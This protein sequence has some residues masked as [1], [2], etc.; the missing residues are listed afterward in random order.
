MN[1]KSKQLIIETTNI[2]P[3]HCEI[4]PRTE[5]KNKREIMSM[6]LFKK[7]IDESIQLGVE[8]YDFCGFGEPLTD[9]YLLD[10]FKLIKKLNP[11]AHIYISTNGFLLN[12][13]KRKIVNNYVT[14]LK[15]S[16]Y[17]ISK[18]TYE[19]AHGRIKSYNIAMRNITQFLMNPKRKTYTIGNLTLIDTNNLELQQWI[20]YFEKLFDEITVWKPHNWAGLRSY[21]TINPD[22][23]RTCGRPI[24]GSPYIHVNGEVSPCCFDIIGQLSIGNIKEKTLEEIFHSQ[25]YQYLLK[26]HLDNNFA[27]IL[28]QQCDQTIN[29][30]SVL[31]YSNKNRKVGELTSNKLKLKRDEEK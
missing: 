5:Y 16:I 10:R 11:D 14:E 25:K 1:L 23:Q 13:E 21:R 7:I 29:D 4:C 6:D 12:H 20:D 19:K 24:N 30:H 17:G 22:E 26:K 15:I 9:K 28:C 2:C 18:Y 31:I 27:D 3:Y 8:S